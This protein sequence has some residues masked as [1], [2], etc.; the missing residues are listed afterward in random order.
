M[1]RGDDS[2]WEDYR[3][4]T[5]LQV[6]TLPIH[7][8][9]KAKGSEVTIH[10]PR[11]GEIQAELDKP[12]EAPSDT[13]R[14]RLEY[15]ELKL[16][17]HLKKRGLTDRQIEWVMTMIVEKSHLAIAAKM[18]VSED[19]SKWHGF[20][21]NKKLGTKSKDEIAVYCQNYMIETLA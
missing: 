10:L 1:A 13:H 5:H 15:A 9:R 7:M 12:K 20:V 16:K 17:D 3:G 8:A 14:K 19:A 4:K 6:P 18:N 21:I 2:G 11:Q